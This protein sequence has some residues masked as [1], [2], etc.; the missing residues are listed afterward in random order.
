MA[1]IEGGEEWWT[2]IRIQLIWQR[3]RVHGGFEVKTEDASRIACEVLRKCG[4]Q[5]KMEDIPPAENPSDDGSTVLYFRWRH[6]VLE[7]AS[8]MVPTTVRLRQWEPQLS[9]GEDSIWHMF[10]WFDVYIDETLFSGGMPA[11][12]QRVR[13]SGM[14]RTI[15]DVLFAFGDGGVFHSECR[16]DKLPGLPCNG[17]DTGVADGCVQVG[18]T[19]ED[20]Q[21]DVWFQV[22]MNY[23]AARYQLTEEQK[24][25]VG[26]DEAGKR[27]ARR[28]EI[29]NQRNNERHR[30]ESLYG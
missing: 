7:G 17:M 29:A 15:P 1:T 30:L 9:C 14:R 11:D 19:D 24:D 18:C 13:S 6:V 23:L 4:H 28:I 27:K 25:A 22:P 2:Q 3:R 8:C 26:T 20:G 10:A 16:K 12:N 5:V 21:P